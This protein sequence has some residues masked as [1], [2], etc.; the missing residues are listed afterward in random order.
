MVARVV[1]L[2]HH[3][4]TWHVLRKPPELV[5]SIHMAV[6]L[7]HCRCRRRSRL[8]RIRRSCSGWLGCR[9][10][11]SARVAATSAFALRGGLLGG[12]VR[13]L[14]EGDEDVLRRKRVARATVGLLHR[15]RVEEREA[16]RPQHTQR[17]G[18]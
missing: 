3:D 9:R 1:V 15:P 12:R 6:P 8:R 16:T 14:V 13:A 18:N 10:L 7:V 17:L 2:L 11:A 4:C 5:L